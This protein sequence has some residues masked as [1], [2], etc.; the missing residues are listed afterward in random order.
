MA[1]ML[2]LWEQ[3]C[4]GLSRYNAPLTAHLLHLPLTATI[5]G[6]Y[7]MLVKSE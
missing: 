1:P 4:S 6:H 5:E 3:N 7:S 2:F